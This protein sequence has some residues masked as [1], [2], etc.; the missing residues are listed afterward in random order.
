MR[1][2]LPKFKFYGLHYKDWIF[3]RSSNQ[4]HQLTLLAVILLH[5]SRPIIWDTSIRGL[6]RGTAMIPSC[7]HH[8]HHPLLQ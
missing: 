7:H 3:F 8:L 1:P 6:M 4:W 5:Y 2:S